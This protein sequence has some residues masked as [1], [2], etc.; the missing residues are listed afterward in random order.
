[1]RATFF[2]N[3]LDGDAT[4]LLARGTDGLPLSFAFKSDTYNIDFSDTRVVGEKNIL[5]L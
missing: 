5:V 1:M 3:Y 2:V 4:N